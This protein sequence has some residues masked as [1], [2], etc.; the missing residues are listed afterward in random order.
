MDTLPIAIAL[1]LSTNLDNLAVGVAYGTKSKHISFSSNLIIAL[2]SGL[3][4][5]LSMSLGSWI[6]QYLPSVFSQWFGSS[7]LIAIGCFSIWEQL[8]HYCQSEFSADFATV[9][10]TVNVP[11]DQ[12]AASQLAP[13]DAL[14]LG[15]GLTLSNL[16]TGIGA[17]MA[18]ISIGLVTTL[19][20]ATSVLM[21]GGGTLL[22][23]VILGCGSDNRLVGCL[24]G[25]G[26]ILLG[27]YEAIA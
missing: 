3:S 22:G 15:L 6:C 13:Q 26:L 16:G 24:T 27:T 9:N 25:F 21:L 4:T 14:L 10:G 1:A 17:G 7:L 19:S 2:L 20:V 11:I 23:K 5:W 18:H 12:P 8:Q